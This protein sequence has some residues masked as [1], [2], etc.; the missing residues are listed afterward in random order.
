MENGGAVRQALLRGGCG[1]CDSRR[2]PTHQ[3]S[4]LIAG[5]PLGWF[6]TTRWR[7]ELSSVVSNATAG[8][9]RVT[10]ATRHQSDTPAAGI[11]Q[12]KPALN[13]CGSMRLT[14]FN[15]VQRACTPPQDNELR[16]GAE[17][18]ATSCS[19]GTTTSGYRSR[20]L[21]SPR[22]FSQVTPVVLTCARNSAPSGVGLSHTEARSEKGFS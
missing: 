3:H 19:S 4:Y 2:G 21:R 9:N 8:A 10:C 7:A 18:G 13:R 17:V 22:Q 6:R 12:P 20:L 14:N 16:F 15:F 5:S 1:Q 11:C